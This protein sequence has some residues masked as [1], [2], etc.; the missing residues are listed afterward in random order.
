DHQHFAARRREVGVAARGG[1][2][3]IPHCV[4]APFRR[5]VI[6]VFAR[7]GT[8]LNMPIEMPTVESIKRFV[9]MGMGVAI[10]PRMCVHWEIERG[11]MREVKVRQMN[12]PRHVY[13][14]SRRGAR[15]PHAA[16]EL[17]RILREE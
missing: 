12:M 11:W 5:H 3:V 15:L 9:Q 16:S 2:A 1:E 17:M 4:E 8:A 6:G 14:V 13:L 10:V 7:D